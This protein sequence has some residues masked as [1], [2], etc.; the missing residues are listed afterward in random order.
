MTHH[1]SSAHL[2]YIKEWIYKF[3]VWPSR[4]SRA[5]AQVTSEQSKTQW[6]C[7]YCSRSE[8]ALESVERRR[9]ERDQTEGGERKREVATE[10]ESKSRRQDHGSQTDL[11]TL[12]PTLVHMGTCMYLHLQPLISLTTLLF[13]FFPLFYFTLIQ[14]NTLVWKQCVC[15]PANGKSLI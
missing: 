15:K 13:L 10:Q 5:P 7:Y 9:R 8:V 4:L 1:T 11:Y 12:T 14:T 2:I 3:V 6:L